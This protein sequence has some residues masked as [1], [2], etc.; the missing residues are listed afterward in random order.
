MAADGEA[1]TTA[2]PG[3]PVQAFAEASSAAGVERV[4]GDA[5]C[6]FERSDVVLDL[7]KEVLWVASTSEEGVDW[8]QVKHSSPGPGKLRL[9]L[10]LLQCQQVPDITAVCVT[11]STPTPTSRIVCSTVSQG[12]TELDM[13]C[14]SKVLLPG[15]EEER[16]WALDTRC[17]TSKSDRLSYQ[18]YT[19]YHRLKSS[20]SLK[21]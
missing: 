1:E 9:G 11:Q 17:R 21:D 6:R 15:G 16:G 14:A 7:L 5:G 18:V 3:L 20:Y 13:R 2:D 10:L 8:R 19:V 4:R 12:T